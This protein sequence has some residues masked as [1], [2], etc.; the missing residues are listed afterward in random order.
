MQDGTDPDPYVKLYLLPDPQKTSKRKTKAAR[1]TCNPTYNEMV[2]V[3]LPIWWS[4][5]SWS[6]KSQT[7]S[8][9]TYHPIRTFSTG[10]DIP[11]LNQH[12]TPGCVKR[13]WCSINVHIHWSPSLAFLHPLYPHMWHIHMCIH[14]IHT[15]ICAYDKKTM[16]N[17]YILKYSEIFLPDSVWLQPY[18][19]SQSSLVT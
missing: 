17:S 4:D 9:H 11:R 14:P 19:G 7:G 8:Q 1:R 6:A 2:A 18:L 15:W 10:V 13:W 12:T 5:H 16:A 3:T